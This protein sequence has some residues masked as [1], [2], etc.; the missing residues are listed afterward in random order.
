MGPDDSNRSNPYASPPTV[1]PER[2]AVAEVVEQRGSGPGFCPKCGSDKHKTPSFT[3]WGGA[4][5]QRIISHVKCQKCGTGFNS[6]TGESNLRNIILYQ[7]VI[8]AIVF[9]IYFLIAVSR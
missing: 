6:K 5:G 7:A 9:G 2:P 1:L 4:I 3:L 8:F